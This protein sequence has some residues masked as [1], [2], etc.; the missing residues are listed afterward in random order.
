MAALDPRYHRAAEERYP[1][2][3]TVEEG[4]QWLIWKTEWNWETNSF[5]DADSIRSFV[6]SLNNNMDRQIVTVRFSD[7]NYWDHPT[8]LFTN[9]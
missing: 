2:Q 6:T 7:G 8:D 3:Y 5:E 4:G 1:V 9:G